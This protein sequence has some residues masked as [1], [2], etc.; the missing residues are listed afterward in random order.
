MKA[1]KVL[2]LLL[3]VA[4]VTGLMTGCGNDDSGNSSNGGGRCSEQRTDKQ[5]WK[6]RR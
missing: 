3:S 2:G 5:R 1:K 6:F 4:M